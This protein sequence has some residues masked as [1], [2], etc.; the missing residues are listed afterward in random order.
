[1]RETGEAVL[2]RVF[3]GA[4]DRHEGRPLHQVILGEAQAA[5]LAGASLLPGLIGFGRSGRLHS[6][7]QVDAPEDPPMVVEIVDRRERIEAFL[8]RLGELMESG[9]VTMETVRVRRT[10]AGEG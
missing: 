3:M 6:D 5:G 9:L 10:G 1:M 7:L 2:L 4:A 8:P